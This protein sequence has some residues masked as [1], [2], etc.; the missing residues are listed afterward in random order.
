MGLKHVE[1]IKSFILIVLI[2]LSLILTFLIW[3]YTP[4]YEFIEERAT[5]DISIAEEVE[6]KDLDSIIKPYKL[7]LNFEEHL[8]GTVDAEEIDSIIDVLKKWSITNPRLED[9]K[10]DEKKLAAFMR[11]ENR[12][13]LLFQGEVPLPVYDGILNIENPNIIEVSFDR[14]II[15]WDDD[16]G[17]VALNFISKKNN[18]RYKS[19]AKVADIQN[20]YDKISD[21]GQVYDDYVDVMPKEIPF[22]AVPANSIELTQ[23]TYFQNE[24][25]EISPTRFRSALFN[26]PN[27]V[28]RS[29]VGLNREDYQDNHAL[30]KVDTEKK[31]LQYVHPVAESRELAIPSE[32]LEDTIDF[33]NEHGGWTDEYR[34]SDMNF[35]TRNVKFQL[36]VGG[37]PVLEGTT[38]TEIEQV[39]GDERIYQYKRPYYTLD[40]SLPSE[41]DTITLPSGVEVAEQLLASKDIDFSTVEEITPAYY[42]K[43]DAELNIFVL[44]PYWYYLKNGKWIRFSPEKLGGEEIGLE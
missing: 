16:S 20:F 42:M 18:S 22:I 10:F 21:E 13:I 4:K 25:Y 34:F 30:M 3:T 29:Q 17:A 24:K 36:Y 41:T 37:L 9:N 28:R 2:T 40:E 33:V 14:I 12:F 7:L 8:K 26:D 6:K 35:S 43:H 31:Q 5:V 23:N 39:W 44:E 11:K 32:L 19:K 1:T 15:E 38:L 27:A